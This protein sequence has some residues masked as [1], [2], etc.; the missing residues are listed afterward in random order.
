[1]AD[2]NTDDPNYLENRWVLVD[3]EIGESW[4]LIMLVPKVKKKPILNS[5]IKYYGYFC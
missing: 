5:L 2:K 1:M 4:L 3:R